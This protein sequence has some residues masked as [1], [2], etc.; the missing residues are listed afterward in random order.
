[1]AYSEIERVITLLPNRVKTLALQFL[2]RNYLYYRVR[3]QG[4]MLKCYD[5]VE[6]PFYLTAPNSTKWITYGD[7]L[8]DTSSRQMAMGEVSNRYIVSPV[9]ADLLRN[10]ENEG[11]PNKIL[12]ET[13]LAA[14]EASWAL[15]RQLCSAIWNG[16]SSKEPVGIT[17]MIE[18]AAPGSQSAVVMGV[19]KAAK[20]WFRNKFTS[21]TANFGDTPAGTQIPAGFLA[22]MELLRQTT[23]VTTRP[24]DIITTQDIFYVM[25][26]AMLEISTPY[27]MI[28]HE[29]M[30]NFGFESFMFDGSSVAWD[31]HCPDDKVYALH[32]NHQAE[33]KR[34][35]NGHNMGVR[36]DSELEEI[37]S[38]NIFD[39]EGSFGI[40]GHPKIQFRD[41]KPR[42]AYRQLTET[43][44]IITS[45]N[46]YVTRMS[47]HGVAG[48]NNGSRW[49]TWG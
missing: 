44:W 7:T 30:A 26:R 5:K 35:T 38:K 39:L 42:Q 49:S 17:T 21:L 4:S 14:M 11:N 2:S 6:V 36:F 41:I 18:A 47:D 9:G 3:R 10:M 31:P 12:Q 16:S 32:L 29:G 22:L 48:S 19:D 37:G 45:M 40:V 23:V 28:T 33:P 20:P 15:Y 25:K 27:H 1:V 8:P 46:T 24:S 13:E 43:R 34:T